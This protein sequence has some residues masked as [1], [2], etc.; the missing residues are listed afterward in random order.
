MTMIYI[1]ESVN[2][3]WK[4]SD[5]DKASRNI[6]VIMPGELVYCS[7]I[8]N[9]WMKIDDGW[10]YTKNS[11]GKDIF[12]SDIKHVAKSSLDMD[13]V[14]FDRRVF[15]DEDNP[16]EQPTQGEQNYYP[17]TKATWT[18]GQTKVTVV[19]NGDDT[20]TQT[21]VTTTRQGNQVDEYV[22]DKNG[23]TI[24]ATYISPQQN[25]YRNTTTVDRDGKTT[26]VQ[27]NEAGDKVTTTVLDSDGKE[28]S[29]ITQ[30]S[31]PE[32]QLPELPDN[33]TEEESISIYQDQFSN[34]SYSFGKIK[35]DNVF[36]IL[37]APYQFMETV[38]R[39]VSDSDMG[40]MYLDRIIAKMPLLFI[41]PGEPKFLAG[42]AKDDRTSYLESIIRGV[43]GGDI[44]AGYNSNSPNQNRFYIFENTW[45][46]YRQ[47]V[48]PLIFSGAMFLK[49][50]DIELPGVGSITTSDWSNFTPLDLHS[51][52][53]VMNGCAFYIDSEVSIND[54]FN[55]GVG[56]SQLE[57]RVNQFADLAREVQFLLG[58]LASN[59]QIDLHGLLPNGTHGALDNV[60]NA[61]Q[62]TQ[63]VLGRGNF[64]EAIAGN[65]LTVVQGGKL[66]FPEI[67]T[68]STY[69]KSYSVNIK[70]RSPDADK[71]SWFLNIWVPMAHLLP[72]VLPKAAGANG[73]LAPFLVRCWYKGLFHCPM[74]II[75]DMSVTRGELGNWSIDG[76]P[77]SVNISLQ[78]KDLY[79]TLAVTRRSASLGQY[80][81]ME[82]IG[83]LDYIANFCGANSREPDITRTFHYLAENFISGVTNIPGEITD[84]LFNS[85][86]NFLLGSSGLL[87]INRR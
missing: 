20:Y 66:I 87:T 12:S 62:F 44:L 33:L 53:N 54:N 73:Y 15:Y 57:Q 64:L 61:S 48:Q 80:A 13:S 8:I 68:D 24:S 6:G 16:D 76:L 47:Y 46:L 31:N 35:I 30:S 37:G 75:T 59:V 58:S 28:L 51:L 17:E 18:E 10:V 1:L 43:G 77:M 49:L 26:K 72:L 25:G 79:N 21:R 83:I 7:K 41:C 23:N 85:I 32:E 82:N 22:V 84:Q 50:Q 3:V 81:L 60:E 14:P 86:Q 39:V 36:G 71:L 4:K 40:R 2:P 45:A 63:D 11:D 55:N 9:N 42:W 5:P 67:W 27:Y 19:N 65:I 38:D 69:N 70:L 74:G 29:K 52:T 78:I 34:K 56:K